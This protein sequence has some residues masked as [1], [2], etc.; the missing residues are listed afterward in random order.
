MIR[1]S[2]RLPVAIHTQIKQLADREQRS[3]NNQMIVML[4]EGI[5]RRELSKEEVKKNA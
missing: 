4:R 1:F 5:E 2:L 3:M